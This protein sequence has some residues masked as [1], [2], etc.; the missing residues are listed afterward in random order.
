M[1]FK[2]QKYFENFL[3]SDET[4]KLI[5]W[6]FLGYVDH[7]SA[8]S[9]FDKVIKKHRYPCHLARNGQELYLVR[10]GCDIP[11]NNTSSNFWGHVLGQVWRFLKS[12]KT[13]TY[14]SYEGTDDILYYN[15]LGLIT[16]LDMALRIQDAVYEFGYG[17][18][19]SVI[20]MNRN[21]IYLTKE[22]ENV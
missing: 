21:R 7:T 3:E 22:N 13:E 2:R 10:N 18:K 4:F 14:I 16:P 9:C 11:R 8:R 6:E 5:Q 17:G 12:D 19:T 15:G 20:L 1:N